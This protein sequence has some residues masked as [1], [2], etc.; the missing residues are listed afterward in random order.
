MSSGGV[1]IVPATERDVPLILEMIRALADYER[2]A[3]EVVATEERLHATLFGPKPA[4]EAVFAYDGEECAGFA[5]YF[6]TY[7]T[8]LAQ[9][10]IYL[11]D[12]Y[13]KPEARGK[14]L[15]FALLRYLAKL[16][17]TR[18]CGRLEWSVLN[19]NEPSIEFYKKLGAVPKA[20]WSMFQLAGEALGKLAEGE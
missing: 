4:A 5:L 9:S 3:H 19:W 15:G 10:G 20:E 11:E 2:L 17:K 16:A 7:S 1:R 8:F 14:G 13:V 6:S 12:L 18:N